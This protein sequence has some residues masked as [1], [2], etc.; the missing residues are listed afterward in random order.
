MN[1]SLFSVLQTWLA[2]S[3]FQLPLIFLDHKTHIVFKAFVTN[4]VSDQE[5]IFPDDDNCY[6]TSCV[7]A[8]SNFYTLLLLF[9][10]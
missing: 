1:S 9:E 10:S 7:V 6:V 3:V 4:E 5:I 2:F 8:Y